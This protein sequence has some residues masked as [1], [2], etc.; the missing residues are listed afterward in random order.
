MDIT[1]RLKQV[2]G[3]Q[4]QESFGKRIGVSKFTISNYENGKQTITDRAISDICREYA[5]NEE[6]LRTGEGDMFVETNEG[7]VAE[8]SM[9]YHLNA[10]EERIMELFVRMPD[11]YKRGA[12]AF[13]EEIAK[14]LGAKV[15]GPGEV[16]GI[17]A[18]FGKASDEEI[19]DF[20]SSI[21]PKDEPATGH[22]NGKEA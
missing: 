9:K 15:T 3:N 21:R 13:V 18:L 2:R 4:S 1:G 6:W 10:L 8:L 11:Q 16:D 12:L 7:R 19:G 17:P 22:E 14:E 5:V 20:L